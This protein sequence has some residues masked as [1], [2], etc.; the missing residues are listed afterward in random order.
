MFELDIYKIKIIQYM[1]NIVFCL[2]YMPLL[3][4]M[5]YIIAV[6]FILND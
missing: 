4:L 5:I 6:S 1:L 2:R 3:S